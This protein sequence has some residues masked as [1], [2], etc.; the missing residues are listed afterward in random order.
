R[1][2]LASGRRSRTPAAPCG[3]TGAGGPVRPDRCRQNWA[4]EIRQ[5]SPT[6]TSVMPPAARDTA[7]ACTYLVLLLP[8]LSVI[9]LLAVVLTLLSRRDGRSGAVAGRPGGLEWR[10][11]SGGGESARR[12]TWAVDERRA[13]SGRVFRLWS[14]AGAA[15][16]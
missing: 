14:T 10:G 4:W 13:L 1:R 9:F 16:A 12:P 8:V 6:L 5:V 2:R 15:G 3:L 7:I 11:E